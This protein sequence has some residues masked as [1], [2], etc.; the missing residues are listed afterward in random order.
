M[1]GLWELAAMVLRV[2]LTRHQN[3]VAYYTP[4]FLL[5][6][7]APLWIN[8]FL[9]MVLGRMVYFFDDEKKLAGIS[10][11]RLGTLFVLLDIIAFIVQAAGGVLASMDGAPSH[12]IQIGLNVYMGGIGLQEL[13]ILC[14]AG[15]TIIFHRRMIATETTGLG[16]ERGN[17]GPMPWRWMFYAIYVALV[18]ITIRII[19]RLVE[20]SHGVSSTSPILR[21][22]VYQYVLD[23]APM[24]LAFLVLNIFH[25]GRVLTGPESE[26]PRLSRAEKKKLKQE[27]KA[28]KAARK[29]DKKAGR[30]TE[31]KPLQATAGDVSDADSFDSL[32][33]QEAGMQATPLR[34]ENPP[35]YYRVSNSFDAVNSV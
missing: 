18:L 12:I 2:L 20:Y 16:W 11:I 4:S 26:F 34:G 9:Y 6:L 7:L 25:P 5:M 1:G 23:L 30:G 14:F 33:N 13:F 3:I 22:E 17:Q 32:R 28:E 24:F 10:A 31:M 8:A 15:L 19:F 29:A 35:R 27:K 21:Y